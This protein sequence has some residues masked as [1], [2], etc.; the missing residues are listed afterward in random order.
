MTT[1]SMYPAKK[2]DYFPPKSCHSMK[3]TKKISSLQHRRSDKP[4]PDL[5]NCTV[6][7]RQTSFSG[8]IGKQ[9]KPR[10]PLLRDSFSHDFKGN[11]LQTQ[12]RPFSA[13]EAAFYLESY[14]CAINW[15][16]STSIKVI[17]L[18]N[19]KKEDVRTHVS[20]HPSS[21]HQ[22]QCSVTQM[23]KDLLLV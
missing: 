8:F 5:G 21:S 12:Y 17:Y 6:T 20:I 4:A 2:K 11:H 14:S 22:I 13:A 9:S 19:S 15:L 18:L 1:T 16:D 10:E 7:C 23:V 3:S